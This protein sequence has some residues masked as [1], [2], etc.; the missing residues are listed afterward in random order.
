M[1]ERIKQIA[2][3]AWVD[4]ALIDACG[5]TDFEKFAELVIQECIDNL[6]WHGHDTAASQLEWLRVNRFGIKNES[7]KSKKVVTD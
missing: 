7:I 3:E 4:N 5:Y 6:F 1:N 2:H